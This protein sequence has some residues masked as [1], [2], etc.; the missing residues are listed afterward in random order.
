MKSSLCCSRLLRNLLVLIVGLLPL[1]AVA[2]TLQR[3]K[4]N[5]SFT[6]GF[7][8][9]YAP[10]S[11]GNTQAA[12]G[13]TIELCQRIGERLKQQLKL[14]DLQIGYQPVAIE[15]M[16]DAVQQ[17]RVDIL[18]SPVD[19]T[20]K[21]RERVSFSLPVFISGLGVILRRDG[22]AVLLERVRNG[23]SEPTPLWRGNIG[24]QLDKFTFALL[25]NT[26]SAEWVQQRLRTL[27][28]KSHVVMASNSAEGIRMVATGSADAFFDDRMVLLNYVARE[29]DG[30]QLL[31][32]ERLFEET[33]AALALGR[34]D[35]DF[36]LLVDRSI[37]ELLHSPQGIALYQ[38]YFGEPSEQTRL[39]FRLYPKP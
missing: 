13:Y 38:K 8:A 12:S 7:V 20:L 14:S 10:F 3:I 9:N 36:R 25:A 31:V 21:R 24:Q 15:D 11:E 17:G 39:L 23:T 2:D 1:T 26:H 33:P 34:D 32:P 6:I 29:P 16:L 5:N 22:P 30:K 28:L 27:G 4:D 19:E 37:S 18:C 35:E